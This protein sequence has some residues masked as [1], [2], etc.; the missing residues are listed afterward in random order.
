[1]RCVSGQNPWGDSSAT[2]LLL[3]AP[4]AQRSPLVLLQRGG[5]LWG[6]PGGLHHSDETPA[7]TALREAAHQAGV[8]P[9][10]VRVRG[11]LV[12]HPDGQAWSFTSVV[13]DAAEPLPVHPPPAELAWVPERDVTGLNL[14]P[15]FAAMWSALRSSEVGLVVDAANV[16]GSRPDG[17]WKDRAGAAERLQRAVAAAGPGVLVRPQGGFGWVASPVLVLE[18]AAARAPDVP[19]VETIRAPA[20]GDDTIIDIVSAPGDWLVVTADRALRA[21]LP[22]HAYPISPSAFL[23]WVGA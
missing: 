16:V 3:R 20:A 8:D 17:W 9:S 1:M 23:S 6:V 5:N 13:A 12:H 7:Q 21:C 4:N 10:L 19:G 14:N 18:G 11:A 22:P 2:G 15:V